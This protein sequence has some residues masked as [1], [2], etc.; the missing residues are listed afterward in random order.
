VGLVVEFGVGERA[1]CGFAGARKEPRPTTAVALWRAI[2]PRQWSKNALVLVAPGAAG[3]LVHA[4]VLGRALGGFAVFCAAASATY[5]ANDVVDAEAD[6]AHP[7]KRA[8]PVA[9]GD[10]APAVAIAAA[11]VAAT[12]AM[13]GGWWLGGWRLLV[14]V[15]A[16]VAVTMAYSLWLKHR[17]VV[18]LAAVSSGFVLRA[19]AGGVAT[20]VTLSEWFLVVTCF[21]ALFL[22]VGK[23]VGEQGM[24]G[25]TG[26]VHRVTLGL[27][28]PQFLRSALTM[29]ATALVTTYCLWAFDRSGLSRHG[30]LLV[31]IELSVAP[32][33]VGVLYVL[34]R[35]DAG[36][37]G[38]PTD[39]AFSDRTLQVLGM[40]WTVL[41]GI[42]VYA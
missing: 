25:A 13:V 23:R 12:A 37:G 28:T 42:G 7:A 3:V 16:Y 14:V 21:G 27:Y 35:L 18:E 20:G 33:I 36:E 31:W 1:T 2:R 26:A 6:R 9:S 22:V 32:V 30:H 38:S 39:L 10:L 40:V 34:R 24:L 19:I 29:S 11:A 17:P 41:V 8:R 5:L 4:A 15:L